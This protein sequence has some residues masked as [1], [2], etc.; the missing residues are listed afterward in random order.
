MNRE[1]YV[2]TILMG[3]HTPGLLEGKNEERGQWKNGWREEYK[4]MMYYLLEAGEK[5]SKVK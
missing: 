2:M 5:M 3:Q 4:F 1:V